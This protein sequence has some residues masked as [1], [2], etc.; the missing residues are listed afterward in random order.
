MTFVCQVNLQDNVIKGSWDFIEDLTKISIILP[1][2]VARHSS[3]DLWVFVSYVTSQ[4]HMIKALHVFMVR[5]LS[6]YITILPSLVITGVA[7]L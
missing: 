2:F 6:R 5:S 7:V 3:R 1:S 4:D